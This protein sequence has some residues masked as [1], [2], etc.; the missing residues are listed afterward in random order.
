M[1]LW[2]NPADGTLHD[3]MDGAAL[4]L[5]SWPQGMTKA[6]AEQ[7]AECNLLTD[8]QKWMSYQAQAMEMLSKSDTIIARCYEN[9]VAVPADWIVYRK[10]LRAIVSSI[11]GDSTVALPTKPNYPKGT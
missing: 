9:A 5:P 2:H 3:D 4:S 10:T 6:S 8:D 1:T 7:I 11:S